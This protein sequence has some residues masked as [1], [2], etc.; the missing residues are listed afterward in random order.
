MSGSR[1][2]LKI[3]GGTLL[4]VV[5]ALALGFGLLQTAL[6][7]AWL[8]QILGGRLS[9]PAERVTIT[10]IGGLVPFDMRIGKVEL[11]DAQGPRVVVADAVLAI[12]PVD[13]LAFRL[14]LR[15]IGARAIR[16]E[17]PAQGSGGRHKDPA[18]LAQPPLAV[19]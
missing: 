17:R 13:L 15:D 19:V 12:A 11:A 4:G 10:G 3:G 2:A 18:P 6:G 14:R 5:L 8:A 16:V 1:R 7:R 9:S